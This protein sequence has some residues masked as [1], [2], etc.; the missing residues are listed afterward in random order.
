VPNEL[1]RAETWIYQTVQSLV[2]GRV[3]SEVAP[4]SATYPLIVFQ[5]VTAV[6]L[7]GVGPGR[8]YS[9]AIYRVQVIAQTPS[10]TS[11]TALAD[12]LD[13]ALHAASGAAAGGHVLACMRER[14]YSRAEDVNGLMYRRS[15]GEYRLILQ[16]P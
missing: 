2:A 3:Y 5:F 1:V 12:Q 11:L 14:P 6:D 13:N 10:L 9:S 15:G 8:I 7:V 4:Q 16:V